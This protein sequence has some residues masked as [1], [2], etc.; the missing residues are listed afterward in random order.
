MN[1][2]IDADDNSKCLPMTAVSSYDGSVLL[3]PCLTI[4]Y[5]IYII[6]CVLVYRK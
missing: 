4:N 6:V 3:W 1:T 2:N 5:T